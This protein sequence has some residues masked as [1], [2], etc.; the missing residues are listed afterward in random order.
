MSVFY[1]IMEKSATYKNEN[2]TYKGENGTYQDEDVTNKGENVRYKDEDVTYKGENG[3]YQD[4]STAYR[5][6]NHHEIAIHIMRT[7]PYIITKITYITEMFL[8]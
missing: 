4:E 8:H 7:V 6:T 1:G 3:T 5:N 2:V